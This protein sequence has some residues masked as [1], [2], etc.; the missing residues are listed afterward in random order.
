M[1][2]CIE[3]ID[4]N[5]KIKKENA[6]NALNSLKE[7]CKIHQNLKWVNSNTVLYSDTIEEAFDEIRYVLVVNEEG[8]YEIDYFV[9]EKY[10]DCVSIFSSMAEYVEDDSYVDFEG[11][12]GV[13]FRFLVSGGECKETKIPR[14]KVK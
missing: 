5:F 9:G 11:E 12:D 14:K 13:K 7:Y 1:G 2:Y 4:R 6:Q 3:L 8:D 10:G